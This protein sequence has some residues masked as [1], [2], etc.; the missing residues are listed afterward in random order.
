MCQTSKFNTEKTNRYTFQKLLTLT[1]SY[2]SAIISVFC[3]MKTDTWYIRPIMRQKIVCKIVTVKPLLSSSY[4]PFPTS[5]FPKQVISSSHYS[6]SISQSLTSSLR[7]LLTKF[8]LQLCLFS[9]NRFVDQNQDL[10]ILVSPT[11]P[12][13]AP[14]H[15]KLHNK[16][17]LK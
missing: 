1:S 10:V 3:S 16:C 15:K 13:M 7:S 5:F 6:L 11:G 9:F 17:L 14:A 2:L 12:S 8:L 4:L